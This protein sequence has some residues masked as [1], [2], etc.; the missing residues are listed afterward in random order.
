MAGQKPEAD[1]VSHAHVADRRRVAD[2]RHRWARQH[3]RSVPFRSWKSVHI[4]GIHRVRRAEGCE[5]S[6]GRTGVCWDNA[7][8][9]SFFAT[10]KN[11]MYYRQGF[12]TRIRAPFAVAVAVAEYIEVFYNRQ[13]LHSTLGYHTRGSLAKYRK[14]ASAA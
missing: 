9:E 4:N 5:N 8:A 13:R 1:R 3:G 12:G 14:A 7:S 2:G 11:E 10:L 6:A